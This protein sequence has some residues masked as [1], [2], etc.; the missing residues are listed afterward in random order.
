MGGYTMGGYGGYVMGGYAIAPYYEFIRELLIKVSG[1]S[2]IK[3]T[4]LNV[5]SIAHE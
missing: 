2:I 5:L 1:Y 4:P 3:K